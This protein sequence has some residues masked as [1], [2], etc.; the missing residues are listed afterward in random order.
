MLL[1]MLL[2]YG[3]VVCLLAGTAATTRW[4][5]IEIPPDCLFV[6]ALSRS[7]RIACYSYGSQTALWTAMLSRSQGYRWVLAAR[8]GQGAL[9]GETLGTL[10]QRGR[11]ACTDE[12]CYFTSSR[13]TTVS[14]WKTTNLLGQGTF[15]RLL[16]SGSGMNLER[17]S[18]ILDANRLFVYAEVAG[19]GKGLYEVLGVQ[20]LKLATAE[21]GSGTFDWERGPMK[22]KGNDFVFQGKIRVINILGKPE[23]LSG[24]WHLVLGGPALAKKIILESDK[25]DGKSIINFSFLMANPQGFLLGYETSRGPGTGEN[26]SFLD[27]WTPRDGQ[28]VR[29]AQSV[30]KIGNLYIPGT[31]PAGRESWG[32]LPYV[33]TTYPEGERHDELRL[34]NPENR[35]T[36]K[37]TRT[38]E[39]ISAGSRLAT[40][41]FGNGGTTADNRVVEAVNVQTGLR[42]VVGI[43]PVPSQLT[44]QVVRPG[45]LITVKGTNL[46]LDGM[47]TKARF[48]LFESAVVRAQD[49]ATFRLPASVPPGKQQVTLELFDSTGTIAVEAGEVE[50][51]NSYPLPSLSG[52]ASAATF[53][54]GAGVAPLGLASLYGVNLNPLGEAVASALP[55]PRTLGG[56]QVLFGGIP[57][58]LL[59]VGPRQIN[60]Q[61][62]SEAL[63]GDVQVQVETR[64]ADGTL[65]RSQPT[66]VRVA[67]IAPA[68]FQAQGEVILV[69][70]VTGRLATKAS[71]ARPGDYLM[72]FGTGCGAVSPAVA[73]GEPAPLAEPL[74]KLSPA[75]LLKIGGVPRTLLFAGL[76]PGFVGLC[77]FNLQVPEGALRE[78]PVEL[79]FPGGPSV[80]FFLPVSPP[81]TGE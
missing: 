2:L 73:S 30:T 21:N 8:E 28:L 9:A 59:Y 60:F 34:W 72:A 10:R 13:G 66:T 43:R 47:T 53:P 27:F 58:P 54:Q 22:V 35:Q 5:E 45:E 71:P 38:G 19:T 80:F 39:N 77:Q 69:D 12:V 31:R 15:T 11:L 23:D 49:D 16:Q 37:V 44:P 81:A 76:A 63:P 36:V 6:D 29:I 42:F 24:F 46:F 17:V 40:I 7:G 18:L 67:R 64:L 55:L 79:A 57:V 51:V 14:V 65:L 61:I 52:A 32:L 26:N 70:A 20:N 50:V 56:T 41:R 68:L 74:A 25:V 48:G 78:E 4:D 33:F 62:P 3:L 1:R 75:P